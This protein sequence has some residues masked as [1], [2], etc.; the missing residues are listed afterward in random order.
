MRTIV[1]D[2]NG[3]VTDGDVNIDHLQ[4]LVNDD[5]LQVYPSERMGTWF[6]NIG[7]LA[8]MNPKYG[9]LLNE[10]A[11]RLH[12]AADDRHRA[13]FYGPAFMVGLDGRNLVD[14]PA[15]VTEDE[16][17]RLIDLYEDH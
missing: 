16:V 14:L 5:A 7:F 15:E 17:N 4:P 2:H 13:A 11:T 1:I 12:I 6:D 9:G 10:K 8:D 3:R